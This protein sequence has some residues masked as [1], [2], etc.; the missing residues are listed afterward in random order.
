MDIAFILVLYT[1][2]RVIPFG[3]TVNWTE[4]LGHGRRT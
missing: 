4:G 1:D 3:L 2:G